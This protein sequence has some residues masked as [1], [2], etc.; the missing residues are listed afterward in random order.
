MT[1]DNEKLPC[2]THILNV[3]A[4]A[5]PVQFL[6][7][8]YPL[9]HSVVLPVHTPT[10]PQAPILM[11]QPGAQFKSA[12]WKTISVPLKLGAEAVSGERKRQPYLGS[13]RAVKSAFVVASVSPSPRVG[14]W[15]RV[16]C[17]SVDYCISW[18]SASLEMP[19]CCKP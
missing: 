6:L 4:P 12:P 1:N 10:P 15:S 2:L 19:C 8:V 3:V 17:M 5:S 14:V 11:L 13:N 16:D 7:P 9:S 18:I